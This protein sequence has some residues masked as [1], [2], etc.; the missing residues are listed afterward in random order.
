MF[1]LP[2]LLGFKCKY[3]SSAIIADMIEAPVPISS[4]VEALELFLFSFFLHF[5][6]FL[7]YYVIHSLEY[8]ANN[9]LQFF[10]KKV[11]I[12]LE[13]TFKLLLLY[14]S[15]LGVFLFKK[16]K[17]IIMIK[18]HFFFFNFLLFFYFI[19]NILIHVNYWKI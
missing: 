16:L 17:I 2:L 14:S 18:F 10:L 19:N 4:K 8:I 15:H 7:T 3:L 9:V 1:G 11:N 13:V 12:N 5:S 6:H